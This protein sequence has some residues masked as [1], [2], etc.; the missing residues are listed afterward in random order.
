VTSIARAINEVENQ[1]L[2]RDSKGISEEQM[3]EF[4]RSF[5][6]FDKNHTQRLDAKEFRACLIS[7]GYNIKDERQVL[8]DIFKL[9]LLPFVQTNILESLFSLV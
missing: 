1:I 6:Y 8:K 3:S 7:L 4:R 5:F 2:T 9:F